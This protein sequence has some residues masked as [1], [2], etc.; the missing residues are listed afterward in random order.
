M[1]FSRNTL[2]SYKKEILFAKISKKNNEIILWDCCKR[3]TS[4]RQL[5][6]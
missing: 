4:R 1:Y 5:I 3:A 6:Y 2:K